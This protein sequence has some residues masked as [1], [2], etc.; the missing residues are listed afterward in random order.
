MRKENSEVGIR[1]SENQ[2]VRRWGDENAGRREGGTLGRGGLIG[3]KD[4][5]LNCN[6][7]DFIL[8]ISELRENLI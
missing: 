4:Q 2:K 1:N 5:F 7:R 3:T 6:E 8:Q